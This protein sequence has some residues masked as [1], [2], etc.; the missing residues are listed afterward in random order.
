MYRYLSALF[1]S[2]AL[3]SPVAVRADKDDDHHRNRVKRYYDREN[4]DWHEW[5][6]REDRAYRHY[7]EEQHREYHDWAK[8]KR[9][10]QRDY[11]KWRH[12]H[13]DDD[14]HR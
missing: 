8:A 12:N 3:I 4:H 9:E 11:W 1:L 13:R 2:V 10:E 5:N 14:D 7:L 6:E